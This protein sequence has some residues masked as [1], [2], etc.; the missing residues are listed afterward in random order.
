M[1][2][3]LRPG[4]IDPINNCSNNCTYSYVSY[5]NVIENVIFTIM[6]FLIQNLYR[7][8]VAKYFSTSLN[9]FQSLMDS[10]QEDIIV[11]EII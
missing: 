10:T 4:F 5:R 6:G 1:E 9:E 11:K 8:I 7:L 2:R 3:Y